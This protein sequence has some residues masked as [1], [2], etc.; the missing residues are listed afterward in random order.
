MFPYL[1][2]NM[3]MMGFT[4]RL[5]SEIKFS[6]IFNFPANT[7]SCFMVLGGLQSNSFASAFLLITYEESVSTTPS[8]LNWHTIK[9]HFDRF[10]GYPDNAMRHRTARVWFHVS[11]TLSPPT[12]ISSK[13]MPL[14]GTGTMGCGVFVTRFIT[15]W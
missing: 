9:W 1:D 3:S 5:E 12:K 15:C 8:K 7:C 13:Y 2:P 11:S 6:A 4:L 14:N 10:I